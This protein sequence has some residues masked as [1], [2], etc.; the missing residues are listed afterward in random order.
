MGQSKPIYNCSI[1][2]NTGAFK[3][4]VWDYKC[5]ESNLKNFL[6]KYKPVLLKLEM[7]LSIDWELETY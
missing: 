2:S 3:N 5:L 1:E 4:E 6:I 7:K